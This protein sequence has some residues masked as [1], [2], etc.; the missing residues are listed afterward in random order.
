MQYLAASIAPA[1]RLAANSPRRPRWHAMGW[2]R[3]ARLG[4]Q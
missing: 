1:N 3:R 2:L 4:R